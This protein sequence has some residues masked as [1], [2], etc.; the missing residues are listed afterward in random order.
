MIVNNIV[1]TISPL[2]DYPTHHIMVYSY[3]AQ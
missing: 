3:S 2:D 1:Y